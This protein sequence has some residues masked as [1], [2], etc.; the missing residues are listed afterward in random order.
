MSDEDWRVEVQLQDEGAAQQLHAAASVAD[1]A[2]HA[3]KTVGE[4]AVISVDGPLIFAYATSRANAE[5]ARAALSDLLAKEGLVA[6][7]VRLAR[8]HDV[9]E[10]WEDPEL[11]LPVGAAAL[12]AERAELEQSE[13]AEAAGDKYPE[14]EVRVSLP[15]HRQ[16]IEFAEHL[17]DESLPCQR[18]WRY[19]L[20]GTWTEVEAEDLAARLRN[21]VPADSKVV[22]EGTYRSVREHKPVTALD[23][24]DAEL[25]PFVVV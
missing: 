8:W 2:A 15:T 21:E 11:P 13:L 19:L 9:A 5:A 16:A 18:H 14:W 10:E 25:A 4:R 20:L 17:R 24:L 7:S 22:V 1:L 12:A 6:T 23:A 3:R